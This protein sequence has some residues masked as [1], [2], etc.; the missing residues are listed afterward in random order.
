MTD[1]RGRAARVAASGC[2]AALLLALPAC[3][4]VPARGST[5][6]T[7]TPASDGAGVIVYVF[8]G[9]IDTAHPELRGRVRKGFTAYPGD[10]PVCNAHGTAV[11]GIVAG[12]SRGIA[13]GADIVDVKIIDCWRMDGPLEGILDAVRW[14]LDDAARHPGRRAVANWSFMVDT[15]RVP[16]LDSAVAVLLRAGIPVVVSAGNLE[17]DA[18]RI[19][20]AN[21]AGAI[22]VGATAAEEPA[23]RRLQ[24][25]A[26]GPCVDVYAAGE[27]VMLP[28]AATSAR[29]HD[30]AWS[31]T[32]MAAAHVSGVAAR[33]LA[34][35]PR[36]STEDVARHVAASGAPAVL[37]SR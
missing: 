33:Y 23:P 37:A 7:P 29:S 14:V 20:P 8:D 21:V 4:T 30:S 1:R 5:A 10:A 3:G 9:G 36:A 18:C 13:P 35:N 26:F 2:L 15:A 24:G 11:A 28:V 17:R 16:A 31:G 19:A 6:S 32:S 22:T 34:A 27:A 25:T 12:S